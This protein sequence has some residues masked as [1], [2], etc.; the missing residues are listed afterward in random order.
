MFPKRCVA[1]LFLFALISAACSS[2]STVN[3]T[4]GTSVAGLSFEVDGT[5]YTSAQTFA[6]TVGSSHNIVA[7]T[8]T[9]S[10]GDEE[11]SF[12]EWAETSNG[13]TTIGSTFGNFTVTAWSGTSAFTAEFSTSYKLTITQNNSHGSFT[14]ASGSYYSPQSVVDISATASG[15]NYEFQ[16]WSGS[17]DIA[18][19]DDEKTTITMNGPESIE[20]NFTS[21]G[22]ITIKYISVVYMVETPLD[23]A[24]GNANNCP[25][26]GPLLNGTGMNCSLRDAL[27]AAQASSGA[28]IYFDST[29]F[30][31]ANTAAQ[32]TI[33]LTGGALYIPSWTTISAPTTA[34]GKTLGNVITVDAGGQSTAF[35]VDSGVTQAEIDNLN[36]VNGANGFGGAGIY[37]D[38]QLTVQRTTIAGGSSPGGQGGGIYIDADGKLT[39]EDSTVS[40]NSAASGGGIANYGTLTMMESTISGN[41]AST[42]AGGLYQDGQAT[43]ASSTISANQS[44]GSVGGVEIGV[45]QPTT[46]KN[47]IVAGNNSATVPPDIVGVY[48]DGGGNQVATFANLA[49]LG[50]Y[51]GQTQ[52]QI[53]LPGSPAVCT[54]LS[55]NIPAIVQA[56]QRGLP[57]EN[58]TYPGYSGTSPCVDTG[59]VQTNYSMSFSAQPAPVAP[60][61]SILMNTPFTAAVTVEESG[62]AFNVPVPV[63]LTLMGTGTLTGGSATTSNGVAVYPNLQVSATG[64]GDMLSAGLALNPP[65]SPAP[66]A[67]SA[68]SSGFDVVSLTTSTAAANA[69]AAFTGGAQSIP[70]SAT[71]T[72]SQTVNAGTVTFTVLSGS[73][74]VGAPVTSGAVAN[75]T[76]SANYVL[77]ANAAPGTYTI[78]AAYNGGG[79]FTASGDATHTLTVMP[80]ASTTAVTS[81]SGN[82]NLGASVTLT[83]TVSGAA[84]PVPTG[85]V[86]F[87]DGSQT[88]ATKTLNAQGTASYQTSSLT[89]GVHVITAVYSGDGNFSGST[90][91][92]YSETVTAPSYTITANPAT[93]SLTSGEWGTVTLTLTP[94]GGFNGTVGFTC[95]QLPAHASCSFSPTS[96]AANGSNTAL[97]TTLTVDTGGTTA[98]AAVS[99]GRSG[100]TAAAVPYL[101]VLALGLLLA[102]RRRKLRGYF[103]VIIAGIAMAGLTAMSACSS[104]AGTTPAG[105]YTMVIATAPASGSGG[106]QA[107][108]LSLTVTK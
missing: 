18:D 65:S 99:Q 24:V 85:S 55:S 75:G 54:G 41:S 38:G 104:G 15:T 68:A 98:M 83:A 70:L 5:T 40:G 33:T 17:S 100:I 3:V 58:V 73:T 44:S 91:G 52:T 82:A 4:V 2:Q 11:Y 47:S 23:D 45:A 27:A 37:T 53:P 86:T 21:T 67:I 7:A 108:T 22:S 48:T 69:A 51:G 77:P 14:P 66:L 89:A 63:P 46:V 10:S 32:N 6:W 90:S 76:A 92:S 36:I 42:D 35:W 43:I 102:W 20:A 30:A 59:S 25:L 26:G 96:L 56:D 12:Q 101:P 97:T 39:L 8:Q 81:S 28:N 93:L 95:S 84:A 57:D 80:A 61:S 1:V 78:S 106:G 74:A 105:Q 79:G 71:V 64:N 50:N 88:L 94:V 31:P 107:I 19:D 72:S 60:A 29:V 9:N 87:M 103:Y 16:G 49:P 13:S 62:S 34:N